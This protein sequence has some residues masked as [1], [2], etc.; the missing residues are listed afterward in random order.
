MPDEPARMSKRR[1]TKGRL[2]AVILSVLLLGA[3]FLYLAL[4]A[5]EKFGAHYD[6]SVY[7]VTA[8]ALAKGQGYRIV[9]LPYEPAQT[10]YPPFYPFLL[11]LIWRACPQF[12]QNLTAMMLL[13]VVAT[14]SFFGLTWRYLVKQGYAT[15]WLALI[16]ITLSVFNWRMMILATT[17]S[18]EMV[19]AALSVVAL[20]LAEKYEKEQ[21]SWIGGALGVVIGLA[22][23][24]RTSGIA[25]LIALAAYYIL[26]RRL[27]GGLLPIA[28]VILFV[29][30]WG[31]W[32]YINRTTAEGVNV[33]YYTSYLRDFNEVVSQLQSVHHQA[34]LTILPSIIGRNV[35]RF[36]LVSVPL[37]FGLPYEL[38]QYFGFAFL[39]IAAGFLR[40]ISRGLRLLHLYVV[41]YLALH[42]IW[43]YPTY[44]RFLLTVL[45]F[46]LFFLIAEVE[47]LISLVREEVTT[48]GHVARKLGAAFVGLALILSLGAVLLFSSTNLYGS[49][50]SSSVK[51]ITGPP[52]EDKQAIEWINSNTDPSDVIVCSRDPMYYLYTGRKATRS[53]R[54]NSSEAVAFQG[55]QQA[56]YDQA[57]LIFRIINESNGRYLIFTSSDFGYQ[58]DSDPTGLKAVLEE[59]P[60][61][62]VPVFDSAD[63]HS[64]IYRIDNPSE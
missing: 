16:V 32:C 5:P 63:S 48:E 57:K 62:F 1:R 60:K 18:A 36:I 8:K 26:R 40:H 3:F 55:Y 37:C 6:D 41:S 11:S 2:P 21:R 25:L 44:S 14:I 28:V 61:V 29:L 31:S 4:L 53:F 17:A 42:L 7:V 23:L 27:L 13:S 52:S 15:A 45:P 46:V 50:A 34:K 35:L 33:A 59:Y 10:K 30:G 43:P 22:F 39:F 51:K 49:L 47:I 9:S 64:V 58:S 56:D 20:Y 24:T 19:Y 38:M 12:P 54:V